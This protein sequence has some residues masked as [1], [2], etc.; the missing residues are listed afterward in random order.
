MPARPTEPRDPLAAALARAQLS[1]R[2]LLRGAGGA[3]LAGLLAACGAQSP[4]APA[5]QG[6]GQGATSGTA[7]SPPSASPSATGV[8]DRSDVDK[9]V[10]W[11][12]WT[13]YLDYDDKTKKYPT[14]E[15]FQ[16]KTGI[17][18]TY[19]EDINDNDSYYGKVRGQLKN[20]DDIGKDVV[21]LT[22]W[23][24]ARLIRNGYT[25]R[26]DRANV[27]NA[28]RLLD[29]LQKVDFD[30]GRQHSL[31]WQ[32]G[33]GVLAW[34]KEKVPRGLKNVSD[35]WR[36]ELKGRVEVLSELRDTVALIMLEQGVDISKAFTADQFDAGVEELRKHVDSGQIRQ[37]KGNDYKE[38]LVSGDALA[39]IGWSGDIFQI[40]AENDDKWGFALPEAGGTLW[41][42]NML[43][44]VGSPHKKNAER[45][46]DYYYD[47]AVAAEVSAYVNYIC[48]VE[49]AREVL[50][51]NKDKEVAA[52]SE[53]PWIFPDDEF[54][55][56][57][58]VFRSLTPE[59]EV[60]FSRTFQEVIGA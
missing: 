39:V 46:M 20:G 1:R 37:V 51:K 2:S 27:P 14:L 33:F 41:S 43:V 35:L 21:V 12:N 44:P 49:G 28:K 59:E 23:M 55:R 22:D 17:K 8:A 50:A 40:N 24:A 4:A 16:R 29:K 9:V 19:A 57:S 7:S 60:S 47:P 25:Q 6:S 48:P 34:N 58:R 45:L 18:A 26:L 52:L 36:P 54:L 15:A 56:N 32:S 42:D 3:G 38:D 5:A 13:L 30:P 10:N 31:T 11:A 53:S